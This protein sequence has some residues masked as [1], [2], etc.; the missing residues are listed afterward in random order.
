MSAGAPAIP[1]PGPLP[2]Q[3]CTANR[4]TAGRAASGSA[5]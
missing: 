2:G 3:S 1:A 4:P 5:S